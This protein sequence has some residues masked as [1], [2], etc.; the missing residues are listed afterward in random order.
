LAKKP[1]SQEPGADLAGADLA[2][3]GGMAGI[4]G[5]SRTKIGDSGVNNPGIVHI[6]AYRAQIAQIRA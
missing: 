5:E 4:T 1:S 3:E 6:C 2:G